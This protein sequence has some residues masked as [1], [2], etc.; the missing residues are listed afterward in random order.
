MKKHLVMTALG[1][2]R[3]GLLRDVAKAVTEL[4]C[5]I[6]DCRMTVLGGEF[7]LLLLAS[8]NWNAVAKL[9]S[10]AASLGKKLDL[11]IATRRTDERAPREMVPYVVDVVALDRPGLLSEVADFFAHHQVDI[12]EMNTWSYTAVNTGAEMVSLSLNVGV[13]ADVHI[14]RL[15][16]EFTDFCDG[17][18]LDAT[19]EPARR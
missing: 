8:G 14:G 17:L 4:G 11:N 10:Q 18:N 1:A 2:D 7:A 5:S 12:E 6:A 13:P 16:D 9:E 19:L 3:P 15:R